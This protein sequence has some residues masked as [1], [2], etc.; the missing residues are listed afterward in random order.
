MAWAEREEVLPAASAVLDLGRGQGA[1][2]CE[3]PV[4]SV[5]A[6]E[7]AGSWAEVE[8]RALFEAAEKDPTHQELEGVRAQLKGL[9][10]L[11]E[12]RLAPPDVRALRRRPG[13]GPGE[14]DGSAGGGDLGVVLRWQLVGCHRA[15]PSLR[16]EITT[17]RFRVG[18][19]HERWWRWAYTDCE[20]ES[21]PGCRRL[22][23]S[24][25]GECELA[26]SCADHPEICAP[27]AAA[28][29][30]P[31]AHHDHADGGRHPTSQAAAAGRRPRPGRWALAMAALY[32]EGNGSWAVRD[33]CGLELAWVAG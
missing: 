32:D 3:A 2:D 22:A 13:L 1:G 14:G 19:K 16:A 23:G 9:R 30:P 33:W 10:W 18:F 11:A 27:A 5:P 31:D 7:P 6:P 17:P 25:L 26:L 15:V 8:A 20:L 29:P 21:T 12:P 28:P 24:E 4:G